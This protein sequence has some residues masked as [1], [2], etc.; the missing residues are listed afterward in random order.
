MSILNNMEI[1]STYFS[2]DYTTCQTPDT[3]CLKQEFDTCDST[4]G[5]N[6]DGRC[7]DVPSIL[8]PSENVVCCWN[9]NK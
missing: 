7:E 2:D 8:Y 9:A 1:A 5:A 4:P 3:G 6:R